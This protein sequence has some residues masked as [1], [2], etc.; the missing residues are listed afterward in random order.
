MA[1]PAPQNQ[2]EILFY[3]YIGII[4]VKQNKSQFQPKPNFKL[5]SSIYIWIFSINTKQFKWG[6]TSSLISPDRSHRIRLCRRRRSCFFVPIGKEKIQRSSVDAAVV[7]E[8]LRNIP[9]TFNLIYYL[10]N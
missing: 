9:R 8:A 6:Q 7:K 2:I 3:L 4:K 1:L 10:I 5:I